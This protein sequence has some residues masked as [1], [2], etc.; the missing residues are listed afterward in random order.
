MKPVH[1]AAAAITKANLEVLLKHGS[2]LKDM[3]KHKMTPLMVAA[4]H[5]RT[6][7]V[8]YILSVVSEST[9]INFLSEEGYSALHY[10]VLRGHI[11]CVMLFLSHPNIKLDL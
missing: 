11:N 3:D 9:Y 2:D 5:G 8:E 4:Y 1:Y 10:A 6:E 7:N